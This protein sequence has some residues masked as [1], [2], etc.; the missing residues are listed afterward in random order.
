M[1][2]SLFSLIALLVVSIA[3]AQEET[4]IITPG[5]G[6]KLE[7]RCV[8]N[9]T[10]PPDNWTFDGTILMTGNYGLHGVS[11]AFDT[12]YVVA[13][14]D[15]QRV[16]DTALSPDQQWYAIAEGGY[17]PYGMSDAITT[18]DRIRVFSTDDSK[19]LYTSNWRLTRAF[20]DD[21]LD[22]FWYD[23]QTLIYKETNN[24]GTLDLILFNPIQKERQLWSK[25]LDLNYS[26]VTISPNKMFALGAENAYGLF[27]D[28]S[29]VLVGSSTKRTIDI[30]PFSNP[31]WLSNSSSFVAFTPR[32]Q[33]GSAYPVLNQLVVFDHEGN[34]TEEI[35]TFI[36]SK[37]QG[38]DL[39][40]SPDERY[41]SFYDKTIYVI[42]KKAKTIIDTCLK[43]DLRTSTTLVWSPD[44][45]Q[46]A[47]F[48]S[49]NEQLPLRIL[50][51][52]R[53]QQ[54]TVAYHSNGSLLG[55][56][57]NE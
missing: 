56:R 6:W 29:W 7:E 53:W 30:H 19:Q 38:Y 24:R 33:Q 50:D 41:I 52:E 16:V 9:A 1:M 31:K 20:P 18:T 47:Y 40:K 49:G 34:Q 35:L 55:W 48:P 44:N 42:D 37:Y 12:P 43:T 13:F 51:L 11:A 23:N 3:V 5:E 25:D 14:F 10:T 32:S 26:N 45:K 36:S 27:I 21:P 15:T 2:R 17:L 54:Y 28:L 8:G 46:L 57:G 4:P 22:L 39:G